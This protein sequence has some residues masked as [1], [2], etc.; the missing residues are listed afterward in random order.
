[1]CARR[2]N[3]RLEFPRPSSGRLWHGALALAL[4]TPG[5]GACGLVP[6]VVSHAAGG[7]LEAGA[8]VFQQ[9]PDVRLAAEA[10]P[11]NFKLLEVLLSKSP[12]DPKLL[13]LAAE[14]IATYSYAFVEPQIEMLRDST[15]A[16]AEDAKTRASALYLRGRDY[17]LRALAGEKK[18]VR[19]LEGDP[20]TLRS[21][22][23][24]LGKKQLPAL[25]WT[26]FCWGNFVNLNQDDPSALND[27]SITKAMMA[28]VLELDES[29]YYGGAHLFFGAL[30]AQL[31]T[32]AGGDPEI[33]RE[34]FER[35]ISLSDGR[36]LMARVFYARYYA[37]RVQ[38]RDLWRAQLNIVLDSDIETWPD[39]RLANTIARQRARFY[40]E[41]E[42]DY[43]L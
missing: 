20:E 6:R 17:G 33:S 36:L 39:E 24:T 40:L 18:F 42:E 37:V 41:H 5:L 11:A 27:S 38:D 2:Y 30:S 21:G 19:G 10:I 28:R 1:M 43:F 3:H 15:P 32:M 7:Y 23:E 31:P 9:E 25:F 29:F 34:H 4:V 22:L 16:E 14:Y 8:L 13:R 12:D 26:A 35:A